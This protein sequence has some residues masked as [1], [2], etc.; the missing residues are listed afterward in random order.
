MLVA[1]KMPRVEMLGHPAHTQETG[2]CTGR[3]SKEGVP[4]KMQDIALGSFKNREILEYL[5]I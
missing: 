1:H 5:R 3:D 4:E 2:S